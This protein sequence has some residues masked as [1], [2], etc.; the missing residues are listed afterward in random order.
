MKEREL[1]AQIMAYQNR[2]TL[3]PE[4]EVSLKKMIRSDVKLLQK[5]QAQNDGSD[6]EDSDDDARIEDK[7]MYG[8]DSESD[9]ELEAQQPRDY[10]REMYYDENDEESGED[11][12]GEESGELEFDEREEDKEE[13]AEGA[14]DEEDG[15]PFHES[16]SETMDQLVHTSAS[17]IDDASS[18][19][20]DSTIEMVD[21]KN[22]SKKRVTEAE[23]YQMKEFVPM[24]KVNQSKKK[25]DKRKLKKL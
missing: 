10:L 6:V 14:L 5:I 2:T 1:F 24:G 7:V 4:Q 19:D 21:L 13:Q 11:E 18:H 12:E 15:T 23:E 25:R 9:F 3:T 20:E 16:A 22:L 8:S 17:E